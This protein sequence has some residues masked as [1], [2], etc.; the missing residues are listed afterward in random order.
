MR[1]NKGLWATARFEGC[2]DSEE[3]LL[4]VENLQ[5]GERP[6][7]RDRQLVLAGIEKCYESG[8]DVLCIAIVFFIKLIH[9]E[10]PL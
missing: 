10:D 1:R 6:A 8:R 3:R 5:W 9:K 4:V 2:A 7:S